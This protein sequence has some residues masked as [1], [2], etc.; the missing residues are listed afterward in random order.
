M[1][2]N[3]QAI[4]NKRLTVRQKSVTT[5]KNKYGLSGERRRTNSFF[6]SIM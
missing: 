3:F 1:R 6:D 5:K 4:K 2:S